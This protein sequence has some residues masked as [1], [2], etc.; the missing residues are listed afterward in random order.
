MITIYEKVNSSEKM[1]DYMYEKTNN[2][3]RLLTA[4]FLNWK[5]G[6]KI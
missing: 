2:R 5:E 3:I 4:V 1:F 6:W